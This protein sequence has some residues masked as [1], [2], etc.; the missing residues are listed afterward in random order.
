MSHALVSVSRDDNM[1][2]LQR[3]LLDD[4]NVLEVVFVGILVIQDKNI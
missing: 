4:L 3:I 2:I 1:I